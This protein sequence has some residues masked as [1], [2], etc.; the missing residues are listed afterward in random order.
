MYVVY[1]SI[2][3]SLTSVIS[4]QQDEYANTPDE[5]SQKNE[6]SIL[7]SGFYLVENILT[8]ALFTDNLMYG[9]IEYFSLTGLPVVGCFISSTR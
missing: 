1:L 8:F 2:N 3:V 7:I 9:T 6:E 4:K 5:P